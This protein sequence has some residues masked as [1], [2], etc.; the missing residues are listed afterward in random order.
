[1]EMIGKCERLVVQR[2]GWRQ[3]LRASHANVGQVKAPSAGNKQ[4]SFDNVWCSNRNA[5][6]QASAETVRERG[7]RADLGQ[8]EISMNT[9]VMTVG[10][11]PS[12]SVSDTLDSRI[13]IRK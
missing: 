3:P 8:I 2:Q 10:V 7:S 9:N 4:S 13:A 12:A 11:V 1:M 5:R 6:V